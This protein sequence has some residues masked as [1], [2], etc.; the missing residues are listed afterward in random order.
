M[1]TKDM[2]NDF[3]PRFF[4]I[5]ESI[6]GDYYGQP[7]GNPTDTRFAIITRDIIMGALGVLGIATGIYTIAKVVIGILP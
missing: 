7:G 6:M 2:V 5:Q 3:H 1:T 4:Q